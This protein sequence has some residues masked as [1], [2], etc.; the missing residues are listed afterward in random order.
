MGKLIAPKAILRILLSRGIKGMLKTNLLTLLPP[1]LISMRRI[2]FQL[3]G[4]S[5]SANS[6]GNECQKSPVG[7]VSPPNPS[8]WSDS[9]FYVIQ[10][11]LCYLSFSEKFPGNNKTL[12]SKS[13][14]KITSMEYNHLLMGLIL[15]YIDRERRDKV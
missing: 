2:N 1:K 10:F 15:E 6:R 13:S 3:L 9:G 5:H 7:E 8:L 11:T 14:S 12:N 4:Q